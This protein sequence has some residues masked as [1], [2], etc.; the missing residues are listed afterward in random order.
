MKK[1]KF[2]KFLNDLNIVFEKKKK[3]NETENQNLI[4]KLTNKF[5]EKKKNF[6]LDSIGC[7]GY[8]SFIFNSFYLF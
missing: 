2:N 5:L 8:F 7:G 1:N 3:L 6:K 4:I